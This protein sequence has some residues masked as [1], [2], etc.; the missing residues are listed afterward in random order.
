MTQSAQLTPVFATDA[1]VLIS[2]DRVIGSAGT[3]GTFFEVRPSNYL[4]TAAAG[5]NLVLLSAGE[6]TIQLNPGSNFIA[7]KIGNAS[8]V[9]TLLHPTSGSPASYEIVADAGSN[10]TVELI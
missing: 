10:F 6:A 1:G 8:C 2:A 3:G 5:S 9:L 7:V 4:G